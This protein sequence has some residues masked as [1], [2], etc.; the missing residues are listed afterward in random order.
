[1]KQQTYPSAQTN[2]WM[3]RLINNRSV[4]FGNKYYISKNEKI[5]IDITMPTSILKM[6]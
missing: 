3:K 2:K 6:Y 4:T 5:E 1:M